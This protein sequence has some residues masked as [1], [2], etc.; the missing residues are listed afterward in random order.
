ME[1]VT[2]DIDP[3]KK[4]ESAL[5]S[6]RTSQRTQRASIRKTGSSSVC[7]YIVRCIWNTHNPFVENCF[8]FQTWR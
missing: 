6:V 3:R 7:T 4:R 2:R 8:R 5:H 1:E